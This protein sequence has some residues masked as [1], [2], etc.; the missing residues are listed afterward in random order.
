MSS[1]DP[2]NPFLS[3]VALSL[4][5][6]RPTS[7]LEPPPPLVEKIPDGLLTRV[8]FRTAGCQWDR[9]GACTMCSYGSGP[10]RSAQQMVADVQTS[11]ASAAVRTG[12]LLVS[13]SGSMCD[14][15][16]V[17]ASA[18]L[19]ILRLASGSGFDRIIVETRPETVTS[20]LLDQVVLLADGRLAVEMGL[21]SSDPLVLRN[22][23]NKMMRIDDWLSAAALLG[24]RGVPL[25]TNVSLGTAFL[26]PTEAVADAVSTVRWALSHGSRD[27]IV[28]PLIVRAWTVLAHLWERGRHVPPSLWSLVEVLVRIGPDDADRLSIS[29]YRDYDAD[30]GG[31]SPNMAVLAVPTTCPGCRD[32]VVRQLGI[33]RSTG[34][35]ATVA[36]LAQHPCRCHDAWR[37]SL[38]HDVPPL[39]DRLPDEYERLGRE[40]LGE[41]WWAQHGNAVLEWLDSSFAQ[42]PT[43]PV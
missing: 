30:R 27:C 26:S 29:W 25:T 32:H 15:R 16:E 11:L 35:F 12:T 23:V 3:R 21:E 9:R 2:R 42:C 41:R 34:D 38:E 18:F 33:F 31:A 7:C 20:D 17:P 43:R 37:A 13:P 5:E 6:A 28:F 10:S 36:G 22:C 1:L 40:V 24:A 19:D 39:R 4:R 14:P 8:W